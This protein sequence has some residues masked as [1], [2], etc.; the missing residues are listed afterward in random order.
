MQWTSEQKTTTLC[1]S[2]KRL[3]E[4]AAAN[5]LTRTYIHYNSNINEELCVATYFVGKMSEHYEVFGCYFVDGNPNAESS[6]LTWTEAFK[7]LRLSFNPFADKRIDLWPTDKNNN[8]RGKYTYLE[9]V[10]PET[11]HD[12]LD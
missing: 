2:C 4:A 3:K 6:L 5:R 11:E 9:D 1:Y 8:R 12:D 7:F 10:I